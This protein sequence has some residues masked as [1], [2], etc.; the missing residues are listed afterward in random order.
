MSRYEPLFYANNVDLVF[1]GHTHAYAR[2]LPLYN[3]TGEW[4]CWQPGGSCSSHL[5]V[6]SLSAARPL[7][8][9][10]TLVSAC[11]NGMLPRPASLA[12]D[13][14]GPVYTTIGHAGNTEGVANP[15]VDKPPAD[16]CANVTKF[17]VPFYA[18]T[19]SGKPLLTYQNDL[20]CQPN[21]PAWEAIRD[22]S[23]GFGECQLLS[24]ALWLAKQTRRV[25]VWLCRLPPL[26]QVQLDQ[27]MKGRS[28]MRELPQIQ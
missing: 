13:T 23:Y 4:H 19:P 1:G 25:R 22:Q 8:I 27:F 9:P 28:K 10:F 26:G 2:T 18:P 16:Y 24:R 11:L 3:Y 15:F 6:A 7:A 17:S 14:C 21:Q 5:L 20:F 12:V